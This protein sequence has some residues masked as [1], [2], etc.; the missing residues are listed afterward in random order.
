MMAILALMRV[1]RLDAEIPEQLLEHG[2][3]GANFIYYLDPPVTVQKLHPVLR[4]DVYE[5]RKGDLMAFLSEHDWLLGEEGPTASGELETESLFDAPESPE[6]SNRRRQEGSRMKQHEAVIQAMECE[7]GY[8]TLGG[9]YQVAPTIT[10]CVWGT[11]TSFA[12][13]RR[14]VQDSRFFF[15]I[16]P[17]LWALNDFR[18]R[19]PEN[20]LPS[21]K[22]PVAKVRENTHAYYQGLIAQVG[23]MR[24]MGTFVPL[25]DKNTVYAANPGLGHNCA[26]DVLIHM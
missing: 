4:S 19:L 20:I 6:R 14:D 24:H 2:R 11:R 22:T 3:S 26:G 12:S 9:L 23:A 16:R 1:S 10:G 5:R 17:G 13:I 18:D 7:G 15:R 8:A 25:Q 21:G